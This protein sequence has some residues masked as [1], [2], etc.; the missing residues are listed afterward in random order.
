VKTT[1]LTAGGAIPLSYAHL[2]GS[3]LAAP[4]A[5]GAMALLLSAHPSATPA[6]V[7]QALREGARSLDGSGLNNDYGYG[8]LD[9]ERAEQVLAQLLARS[10]RRHLTRSGS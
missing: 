1:D 10:V 3:S 9:V 6:Q 5:A 2:T 8:V 4:E 7:E